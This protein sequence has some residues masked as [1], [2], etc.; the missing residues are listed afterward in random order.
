M[1]NGDAMDAT[2]LTGSVGF[3]TSALAGP[4]LAFLAY[5]LFREPCPPVAGVSVGECVFGNTVGE[6]ATAAGA[7][8]LV[9]G[10]V[11]AFVFGSD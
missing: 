4:A 2:K 6:F 1:T 11:L 7:G 9:L 10:V 8:C 3:L 5:L